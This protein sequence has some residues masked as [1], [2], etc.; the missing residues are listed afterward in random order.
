MSDLILRLKLGSKVKNHPKITLLEFFN[1]LTFSNLLFGYG[2]VLLVTRLG[3]A[4]LFL[5]GWLGF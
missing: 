3:K 5:T 1:E 4:F 2:I